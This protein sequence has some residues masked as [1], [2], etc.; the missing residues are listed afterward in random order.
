MRVMTDVKQ[1]LMLIELGKA[2]FP[3][4]EYVPEAEIVM[5]QPDN[6]RMPQIIDEGG[7]RYGREHDH[8]ATKIIRPIVDRVNELAA[9][10]ENAPAAPYA[11]CSNFR[12]LAEYNNVVLAAR[13]DTDSGRG[14]GFHFVTWKHSADRTGFDYGNYTE[15]YTAAKEDFTARSGLVN[16]YRLFTPEQA[17]EIRDAVNYRLDNDGDLSYD[18]E[19]ELKRIV[20]Q[21]NETHPQS[22]DDL[23]SQPVTP[24]TSPAPVQIAEAETPTPASDPVQDEAWRLT[25]EL[26]RLTEPNSPSK[27]HYMAKLSPEFMFNA[28]NKD[29]E[30]LLSAL[31]FK[32]LSLSN[33]KGEKGVFAFTPPD[34]N[35]KIQTKRS[36]SKSSLLNELAEKTKEV[37][38]RP[39]QESKPPAKGGEAIE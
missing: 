7:I 10:W 36:R 11:S 13:D 4:A 14:H 21:L 26:L 5:V 33:L 28:S 22:V 34:K 2:G 25:D 9:A 23:P 6:D 31:P 16:R 29:R 19:K 27:T 1:K 30:R 3:N 20:S 39:A 8:M 38:A 24:V 17:N 35:G 37:A 18:A 15:D 12:I 32:H